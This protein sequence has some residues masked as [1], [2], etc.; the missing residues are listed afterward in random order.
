MPTNLAIDDNLIEQARKA[1]NHKKEKLLLEDKDFF[2]GLYQVM[3]KLAAGRVAGRETSVELPW[4]N[5][6]IG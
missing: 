6:E 5:I 3:K 1:G 4:E 2:L